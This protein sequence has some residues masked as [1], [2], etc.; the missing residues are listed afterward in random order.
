VD[1]VDVLS[2]SNF[3]N[4][5]VDLDMWYRLLNCGFRIP[6]SA[7]T[8]AAVN[9]L[10]SSPFGGFRT[11]V[12]IVDD[13]FR[14]DSWF[15]GLAAGRTFVTN[16]PL[17]TR[18]EIEGRGS[19]DSCFSAHP[20]AVVSG[21]VAMESAF[22][23]DRIEIVRNGG[24]ALTLR[25][26]PPRSSV[27]TNFSLPLLESSWIAARAI[28]VKRGWIVA[29][30]SLFAH[31]SPVYCTVAGLPIMVRSDAAYLAQWVDDLDL[32]ARTKGQWT[33]P[34]QSARVF[35]ELAAARSWY[36]ER[37]YGSVADAGGALQNAPPALSCVN[38]PNPFSD[39]TIIDFDPGGDVSTATVSG[40]LA[41][42]AD[43][44]IYDVS[45]RLVR[46]LA[47]ARFVAGRYRIIWDGRDE[48]GRSASS[49]IY[50]AR[51]AAAGRTFNRKMILIR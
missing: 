30:D 9:R 10:D 7:G 2:Y 25:F 24:I 41:I 17:F 33:D 23:I 35:A 3:R 45:G 37:A 18:F 28:G 48:Q 42:R 29:G 20:G 32:L 5:G 1:A 12:R 22:P 34:S 27:D 26:Q 49:G 4:G 47:G 44:V 6:A 19:G 16:G 31:T 50:F 36:E 46:R 13:G 11:Y 40:P 43:L 51:L 15:E 21:R 14:A 38:S 39:A 8:D